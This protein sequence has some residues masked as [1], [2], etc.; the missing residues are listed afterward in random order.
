MRRHFALLQE[1]LRAETERSADED[2]KAQTRRMV[3]L[4]VE[5]HNAHPV[6]MMP[7][8]GGATT[9]EANRIY[10]TTIQ[11]LGK[12]IDAVMRRGGNPL[13][14]SA[15]DVP[16][17]AV[18]LATTCLRQSLQQH[19]HITPAYADVATNTIIDFLERQIAA[20]TAA[21]P[22]RKR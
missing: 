20:P 7:S 11:Q 10:A 17:L 9:D 6:G 16:T 5:V 3:K 19:G 15:L 4:A 18:D 12:L 14:A 1:A 13:P 22:D 2:W 8:P 21:R